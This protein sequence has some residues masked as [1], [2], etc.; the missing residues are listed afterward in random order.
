MVVGR[1]ELQ[2]SFFLSPKSHVKLYFFRIV[3]VYVQVCDKL[4]LDCTVYQCPYS[5]PLSAMLH[6]HQIKAVSVESTV[7]LNRYIPNVEFG[8]LLSFLSSTAVNE[9]NASLVETKHV[10]TVQYCIFGLRL[11]SLKKMYHLFYFYCLKGYSKIF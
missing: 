4:H 10:E 5:D 6:G 11:L 9:R 7:W 2:V 8:R 1:Q 3:Y